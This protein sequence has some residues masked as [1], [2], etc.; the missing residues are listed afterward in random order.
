[1]TRESLAQ[2][3]LHTWIELGEG[4]FRHNLTLFRKRIPRTTRICFVVKANAYGHGV[5]HMVSLAARSAAVDS[6]AVHAL[7]E[8]EDVLAVAPGASVLILGYVPLGSLERAVRPGLRLTVWNAETVR[9]LSSIAHTQNATVP[10]HLKVETGTSRHGVYPRDALAMADLIRSLP[11]VRLEGLS[12]HYA[13]IEDTTDYS[14]AECQTRVFFDVRRALA[15][16][17]HEDLVVHAACSAAALL[18]PPTH[19]DMIRLGIAGYGLWPSRE[20]L[21]SAAVLPDFSPLKPV[22]SWRARISQLR[23]VAAGQF[24]GYG[25]T[26][27]TTRPSL[28]GIVPIGYAEGYPRALSGASHVL[29]RGSRAPVRGRICMNITIVD[30]TDIPNVSLEEPVVLIGEDGNEVI[31]AA[32]LAAICGTISYEVVARISPQIPRFVVPER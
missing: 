12:T 31:T 17:R 13:N 15:N 7:A 2:R 29:V 9:G 20:T 4:A 30:L 22:L 6:F 28:L 19:L 14:Y 24:V 3:R 25:C 1:M 23:A 18:F 26:F 11:G 16:A 32:D 27:R 5:R 21:V 8:A 10:L